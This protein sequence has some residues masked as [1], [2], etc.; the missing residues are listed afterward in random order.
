MA[1]MS[2]ACIRS[3]YRRHTQA[4]EAVYRFSTTSVRWRSGA[5]GSER[6]ASEADFQDLAVIA[7]EP[8][9]L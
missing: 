4:H 8:A 6:P 3:L 7:D 2:A 1:T 9:G 5:R